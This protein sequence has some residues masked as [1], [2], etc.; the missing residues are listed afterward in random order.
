[1]LNGILNFKSFLDSKKPVKT[2]NSVLNG[3]VYATKKIPAINARPSLTKIKKS[4]CKLRSDS[5][6]VYATK[7][8][9]LPMRASSFKQK[10][11]PNANCVQ[12]QSGADKRT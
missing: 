8:M 6:L 11:S 9:S 4:E 3:W 5:I 7:K 1:M 12:T 10:K 2:K